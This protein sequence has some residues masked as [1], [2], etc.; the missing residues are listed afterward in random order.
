M[1][2][3]STLSMIDLAF[4]N[5]SSASWLAVALANLNKFSGSKSMD[6]GQTKS[7]ARLLAL[8]YRNMKYSVMQLFF[9]R[10]KCG[11]FGRFYGKVDP[12][13]I[14]CA[15]RDF[16]H[17]CELKRQQYLNEAYALRRL[18]EERSRRNIRERWD[19]CQVALC[20]GCKDDVGKKVF[21]RLDLYCFDAAKRILMLTTDRD[22]YALIEG[23]FFSVFSAVIQRYYPGVKVQYRLRP[24][25]IK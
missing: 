10:F 17:D 13:M 9:Y 3:Y 15:L 8:E 21:A 4:G 23:R 2:D 11:D 6:D 12:M 20:S 18:E 1:F 5:G 25:T 19:R 24:A 7:L 14:T 22:G 16:T